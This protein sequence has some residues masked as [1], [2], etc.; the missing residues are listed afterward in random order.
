M[1][2]IAL[3]Q[4]ERTRL[5]ASGAMRIVHQPPAPEPFRPKMERKP[6]VPK[7]LKHGCGKPAK[8]NDHTGIPGKLCEEHAREM[9]EAQRRR[10]A[11]IPAMIGRPPLPQGDGLTE[12]VAFRVTGIERFDL[13]VAAK[14]A[15]MDL[16]DWIRMVLIDAAWNALAGD[17]D[18]APESPRT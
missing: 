6:K 15:G 1:N 2:G 13:E 4:E 9:A 7:C 11:G 18:D 3:T 17:K 14:R 12:H 16:S 10:R 5:L 8:V